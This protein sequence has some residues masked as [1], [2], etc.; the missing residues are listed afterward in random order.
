MT[1]TSPAPRSAVGALRRS[2]VQAL[3]RVETFSRLILR[4]P[5]RPY[6]AAAAQAIVDSVL[7]GRGDTFAVMMAR[8]AGKNEAAAHVEAF[9]LNACRRRGGALV[10]AAPTFRPQA[11]VSMRRLEGLLAASPLHRPAR[12]SGYILRLGNAR[13]IFLSAGEQSN[14]VGATADILLEGD[15]AQAIDESKWN[16]DFRPMGASTNVTTVLW[17]TS[18]TSRTLL[19]RTI[20]A[21]RWA[22]ERDHRPRVFAT[23]WTEVAA[24]VPAYGRYV[25]G[26][27][28]RLGA[29]HPLVRSQYLLEEIDED[30]RMFPAATRALMRGGHARQRGPTE[31]REYALLVD[32][33][34]EV[35]PTALAGSLDGAALRE[36]DP[37]RDSTALTVVEVSRTALGLAAYLAVDRY[38]WTGVPHLDLAGAIAQLADLWTARRV[39][40][41]ATGLGAGLAALLA[42]ALGERVAP[43]VFTAASKSALGWGFLGICGTGR[44]LDHREDDSPEQAQFWREVEA[45]EYQVVEGPNRAIRWGVADPSLHDDLLVSAALC[46]ALEQSD[47]PL[48]GASHLVEAEDPLGRRRAARARVQ[49]R[50]SGEA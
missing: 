16:R 37:R 47:L 10:K 20:R 33:G 25:R 26:E 23:P 21:L 22:E 8:Q 42:R 9:L 5:L 49:S 31:G 38:R 46:A 17:G 48:P 43:F 50:R 28:A 30:A 24:V 3:T 13:A 18:W 44:F 11:Q 6:Q 29:T 7:Q 36:A 34:G 39:V 15:E 19:A 41:D 14:V 35:D 4:R 27:I 40:V 12:E 2:H 32:V 45:A 1:R